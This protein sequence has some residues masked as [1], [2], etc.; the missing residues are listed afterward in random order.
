VHDLTVGKYDLTVSA[1]P[2]FTSKREEAAL[3][4]QDWLPASPELGPIIGDLLR[5]ISTGPARTRSRSG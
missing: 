3:Q 2:S 4:M 5:R 1:G